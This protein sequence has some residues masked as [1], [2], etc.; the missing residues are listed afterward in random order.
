L[1][2]P[3]TAV[4]G[5]DPITVL[6][7]AAAIRAVQAVREGQARA[8]ALQATHVQADHTRRTA[9]A[10]ALGQGVKALQ[11]QSAQL[12]ARLEQLA[13]L[14][15]SIGFEGEVKFAPLAPGAAGDA[16]ALAGYLRGLSQYCDEVQTILL[17]RAARMPDD[18]DLVISVAAGQGPQASVTP[19]QRLLRRIVHLGEPPEAIATVARSLD[20]L[21]PGSRA[22]LLTT[23]LRRL[24][25]LHLEETERR[26]TEEATTTIMR[27]SLEDLGYEVEPIRDTLFVEGGVAHFRRRDWGDYMVRMRVDEQAHTTNFN[28]I[29]AASPEAN[30]SSREDTLA[31]DR[32][33]SEFPKLLETLK[34]RGATVRVTRNLGP[35]ELP[36]QV[37]EPAL[38]PR[39]VEPEQSQSAAPTHLPQARVIK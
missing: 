13:A 32:W 24:I 15:H 21:P 38:L 4:I 14:A 8:E 33:C 31:E 26:M 10:A 12:T 17:T 30:V 7:S 28:V 16:S 37:V 35:G 25:Q 1:S 5:V 2:G 11:D 20:A 3:K 34:R 6:L 27:Q 23:E 39:F 19:S 22:E 36:V 18:T 9:L 29:R